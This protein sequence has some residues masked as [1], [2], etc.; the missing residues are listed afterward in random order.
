M[1]CSYTCFESLKEQKKKHLSILGDFSFLCGSTLNLNVS[2]C[3]YGFKAQAGKAVKELELPF[4]AKY[5]SRCYLGYPGQASASAAVSTA[6][7]NQTL[8][9]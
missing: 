8:N 6:V 1:V 4:F 3:G 9:K 7:L 5:E 2:I